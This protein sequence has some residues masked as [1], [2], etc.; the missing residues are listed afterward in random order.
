[1]EQIH[2]GQPPL[3]AVQ[4]VDQAGPSQKATSR[5]PATDLDNTSL[6]Q[7]DQDIDAINKLFYGKI[8]Y[9]YPPV[10]FSKL[11]TPGF[12]ANMLSQ[13][14]GRWQ[15][16]VL[17]R[18]G[19]KIWVA[20][21]GTNQALITALKFPEAQVVGS[22]LSTE[23]LE[24][25]SRNAA[26]LGVRNLEL[27]NESINA[28]AYREAFDYV[29]CTGVIHHNADPAQSL[30]VLRRALRPDGVLELMVY[31]RF[32]RVMTTAFQKAVRIMAGTTHVFDYDTELRLSRSMSRHFQMNNLMT[33][34][35][36][37]YKDVTVAEYADAL[38][39]PV[40]H[41]YTVES[42][43][44][45]VQSAGLR[46]LMPCVDQFSKV[47]HCDWNCR[48]AEPVLQEQYEQ[49]PDLPRWQVANLLMA[50]AS[51][52]LWFYVQRED[53]TL[54]RASEREI[55]ETFLDRK[56]VKN[57]TSQV[58][59][60][61]DGQDRYT[62]DLRLYEFPGPPEHALARQVYHAVDGKAS[63]R[64]IFERLGVSTDFRTTNEI[65][66]RLATSGFPHL[67]AA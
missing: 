5:P 23:S 53:A 13:D 64:E 61:F 6:I 52:M 65:R 31:N 18:Q 60:L 10:F 17:P 33:G 24:V 9:P 50:E 44:E 1:M 59:Y 51:P 49:L 67:R 7:H 28:V 42:L 41:S 11:G 20:G 19:G 15:T 63:M 21:C 39:Q 14:V 48:F 25:C 45:M 47:A 29:I 30:G 34:F 38:I 43:N 66:I 2:L 57:K 37:H 4:A 55:C 62:K 35:L 3:A 32:H 12:W 36:A 40:E 58:K 22:D 16:P 27:H 54:S 8:Q 56:F 26:Q 46:V